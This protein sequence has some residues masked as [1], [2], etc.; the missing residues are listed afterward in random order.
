MHL[1]GWI[2]S[3]LPRYPWEMEPVKYHKPQTLSIDDLWVDKLLDLRKE[4]LLEFRNGAPTFPLPRYPVTNEIYSSFLKQSSYAP[5]TCPALCQRLVAIGFSRK[6]VRSTQ[7]ASCATGVVLAPA[8]PARKTAR[9]LLAW[10]KCRWSSQLGKRQAAPNT[11][12]TC[13]FFPR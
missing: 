3:S 6:A 9:C 2:V 13:P 12:D 7:A 10:P 5:E 11:D 4:C 1:R 8:A